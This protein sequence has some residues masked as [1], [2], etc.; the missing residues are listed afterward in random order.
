MLQL[1]KSI[2]TFTIAVTF[3]GILATG[4]AV[5]A[6]NIDNSSEDYRLTSNYEAVK[7]EPD[8]EEQARRDETLEKIV[9]HKIP[10]LLKLGITLENAC[11]FARITVEEYED[12]KNRKAEA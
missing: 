1:L 10:D 3:A 9:M 12:F 6:N 5:Q 4:V 2:K 11:E 8:E 7:A